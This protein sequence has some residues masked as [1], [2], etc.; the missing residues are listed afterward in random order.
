[1]P[2]RKPPLALVFICGLVA[3]GNVCRNPRFASIHTVDVV[4]L[5]AAGM[6]FGVVL[7]SLIMRLRAKA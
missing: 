1:M 4:S 6:C 2:L 5:L 3:F 7:V